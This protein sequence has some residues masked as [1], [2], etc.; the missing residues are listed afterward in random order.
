MFIEKSEIFPVLQEFN[1]WW[2]GGERAA[3]PTWERTAA[4]ELSQWIEDKDSIRAL[5]LTG[6]RQVGKTTL[7]LQTIRRLL[8]QGVAPERVIYATFDHP[9]LKLAGADGLL[10]IWK[11]LFPYSPEDKV[12]LFLDEVQYVPDWQVWLKHQVDFNR[13]LR[14]VVTGSAIPLDRGKESGVGRW[15][16]VKLPTLS[17]KEFLQLKKIDLPNLP[18]VQSLAH[19]YDWDTSKFLRAS[20]SAKQ[21]LPHFH[22]YL[23]RGGFP[24]PALQTDLNRTQQ[25]LREDIV[26]KVL[27]RDMTAQFGVRRVL[28]MEK[29]FLYLCFHDGGIVDPGKIASELDGV[30]KSTVLTF[31]DLFEASHLIYRQK[32][33][34]YGKEI[35]RGKS[36]YY[37]ADPAISGSVLM[38]GKRLLENADKLGRAVEA[39][40]F[41][42]LFTRYYHRSVSFSYWQDKAN[43]NREVDVIAD[44]V[45]EV[46]PFEVKYQDTQLTEKKIQGLRHFCEQKE[47]KRGY[48]ITQRPEEFGPIELHS[49]KNNGETKKLKS[50]IMKIPATLACLWLS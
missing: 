46:I 22:D 43:K 37:L 1:P 4:S 32:P 12:F 24:E 47:V 14:I 25:L 39:A 8:A 48:V 45:E 13:N 20:E 38:L 42:H 10:R 19:L 23:M 3:L 18:N 31:L 49:T 6:P 50:K 28:E 35:L 44:I 36:K 27:K 17:F 40:F 9:I 11:E 2:N 5:L 26:D 29:V 41:K 34:G 30:S 21:L 33:F 7:I 16:T 15:Q